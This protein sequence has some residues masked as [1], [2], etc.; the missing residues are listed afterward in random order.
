MQIRKMLSR[1]KNKLLQKPFHKDPQFPA[2]WFDQLLA[3]QFAM[4]VQIGSNDGKTGDPL[5][6]LLQK[7]K[8]WKAL[9]VEP[10][11][12]AFERLKTNYSDR[13][14]FICENVA[15]NQ[16]EALDFY[17]VDSIAKKHLQDLPYWFDQLG[18]FDKEHILKHFDG[19]LA[20]FIVSQKLQGIKLVNLLNKH[21]IDRI[22]I[23]HIDTEGYDWEILSQLD[24]NKHCPQFIMYEYKHLNQMDLQKSIQ[25]LKDYQIFNIGIDLLAVHRQINLEFR[26]Q[27]K[28]ALKTYPL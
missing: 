11:P 24:L 2:Y 17:W 4:L 3:N 19:Q 7:N 22:D 14:R 20:P 21:Q 6:A 23:L 8:K 13:S 28:K 16:G 5:H 18:S 26:S 27:M 9:L 12:Y 25:F 15:I 1:V 10:V